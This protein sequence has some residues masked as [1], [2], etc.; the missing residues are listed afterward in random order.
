M[1][2]LFRKKQNHRET[3]IS[4]EEILLDA[5]NLPAFDPSR[6]EGKLN[7][8]IGPRALRPLVAILVIVG[9]V[10]AGRTG[11][12]MAI[13]GEHFAEL[14]ENNRLG[15]YMMLAE[16]GII[17]D[18]NG[19]PLAWN[20]PHYREG[21]LEEYAARTYVATSGVGHLLGYVRLPARDRSGRLFRE[22]IEGISGVELMHDD[23]LRGIDGSK[24]VEMDARMDIVSEGV[25]RRPVPGE[26]LHLTV[27]VRL[28][29]AMN[30]AIKD[31]ADRV[32]F[33]GGAGVIMDVHTGEILV[34]T[35]YPE[36]SSEAMVT[37]NAEL[38][39]QY[40]NDRRT[41]Y[42]N[43]TL[44]GQYTPGSIVKPFV[45]VAALNEG[46]VR[47]DKTFLSTGSLRLANPYHPGHYSVFTDWRAHGVVDMRR[48]LAVSSNVYFYYIGGGFGEQEGLGIS[49]I[50]QYMRMFGFGVPTN[51][52]LEGERRGVIP[53]PAWKEETFPSDP[54]WRIG[55]TYNTAVGQYGFQVTLLQVVRA[56][57][58]LANGGLLLTPRLETSSTQYGARKIDIPE[59]H[60][61][62]VRAGMR[63][64]V[65]DGTS[66][67]LKVPY[68]EVAAKTGTAE[69]G[70]SNDHVHSWSMGYFPYRNP[71]YAYVVMMEH[72][73][74]TNLIGATYVMRQFMDWMHIHT[75]EYIEVPE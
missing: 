7:K 54:M 40:N 49:R 6:L 27:D 41:P 46:I 24:I 43:R 22:G 32:P 23:T 28:Q 55:D 5:H 34:L 56:M 73:P 69:V 57:G 17:Y 63:D 39:D 61:N 45:A 35:S 53:S 65:L 18:R 68:I 74:R 50:E 31:L 25:I 15:S 67:G 4:P 75:P 66:I 16:R 47:P 8:P 12:L 44:A 52:A 36:Y 29:N 38:I 72:G 58:A 19:V 70:I 10:L 60:M 21:I 42:L 62:I 59:E 13:Q 3:L 48:A 11:Q 14:S 64:A 9:I 1:F 20:T 51:I 37:G 26:P 71:R 30:E 33:R 2:S